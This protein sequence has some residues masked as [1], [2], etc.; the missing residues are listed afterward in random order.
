MDVQIEALQNE[1]LRRRT[2]G[3]TQHHLT[4]IECE[5]SDDNN[6]QQKKNIYPFENWKQISKKK[7][8]KECNRRIC[9]DERSRVITSLEIKFNEIMTRVVYLFKQV[10]TILQ[11]LCKWADH[12]WHFIWLK[13]NKWPQR[14]PLKLRSQVKGTIHLRLGNSQLCILII[15]QPPCRHGDPV[16]SWSRDRKPFFGSSN[17]VGFCNQEMTGFWLQNPTN[18]PMISNWIQTVNGTQPISMCNTQIGSVDV[19]QPKPN[20]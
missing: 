15:K 2:A 20:M 5:S 19:Q 9:L 3:G 17:P 18:P 7:K 11:L 8:R 16:A 12:K 13:T 14:R 10:E 4:S 6:Q 1:P